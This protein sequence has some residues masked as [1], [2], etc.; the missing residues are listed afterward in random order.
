MANRIVG[1]VY[2]IDTGSA[3]GAIPWLRDAKVASVAFWAAD[4]TGEIIISTVDTT[5]VIVRLTASNNP[6]SVSQLF[7]G[8][9]NFPDVIKIPTLTAGT[10]WIYFG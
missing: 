10:A 9:V 8:G 4:T 1:N 3:N 5:D 2:I 7:L 6:A